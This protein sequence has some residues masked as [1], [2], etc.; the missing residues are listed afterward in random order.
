MIASEIGTILL[1]LTS[2][3]L[4]EELQEQANSNESTYKNI[5][6][7]L[8][9]KYNITLNFPTLDIPCSIGRKAGYPN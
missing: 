4:N 7:A 8:A 2:V 1:K 6:V 5:S 3:F 9:G